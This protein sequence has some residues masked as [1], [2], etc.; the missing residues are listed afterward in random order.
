MWEAA[1]AFVSD[2]KNIHFAWRYF[3]ENFKKFVFFKSKVLTYR[4]FLSQLSYNMNGFLKMWVSIFREE[5]APRHKFAFFASTWQLQT[6]QKS[7]LFSDL[8]WQKCDLFK[9]YVFAKKSIVLYLAIAPFF[10]KEFVVLCLH[11]IG[12]NDEVKRK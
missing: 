8:W 2:E 7:L 5:K 1:T 10:C 6:K 12:I 11:E 4:V 3:S 9:A